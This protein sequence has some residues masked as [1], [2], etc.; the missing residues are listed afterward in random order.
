MSAAFSEYLVRVVYPLL[1]ADRLALRCDLDWAADIEPETV[2]AERTITTFRFVASGPFH[3]FKPI[4]YHG[5]EMRWSQGNNYL[6]LGCEDGPARSEREIYPFFQGDNTCSA[7]SLVSLGAGESRHEVRVFDP[8][9]YEENYLKRYPVLYMQDG[10]NLFFP[11]EAFLGT[12]WK[13]GETLTL[14]DQMNAVDKMIV[15]GVYPR[16]RNREYT[17]P[18]YREYGRFLVEELKPWVDC[19]FRTLGGPDSTAVMGSSL[20][21]VVSFYLAWQ[22][23]EV[24]GMAACMSSTF[25]WRDDLRERVATEAK[26]PVRFY[27]DSGWPHDNY[28]VTRDLRTRLAQR[29]YEQGRDLF[30]LAFPEAM[31]S[32][33]F[34][35]LR[36]HIPIQ[37]FFGRLRQQP[38]P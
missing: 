36:A 11:E 4:L 1:P 25:G 10:Q 14:L 31:H 2:T 34:W 17:R 6:A 35:A 23:P 19:N 13:I 33:R 26:R 18:G 32:E 20:G 29:G 22:Y 5:G 12:S 27:L 7:R 24:F 21:G 37:L 28:E 3:Y 9:G 30:Y 38:I 16:D 8:P 15:V